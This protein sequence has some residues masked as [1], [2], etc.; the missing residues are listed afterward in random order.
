MRDPAGT[1]AVS[2]HGQC[3]AGRARALGMVGELLVRNGGRAETARKGAGY[4]DCAGAGEGRGM[5]SRAPRHAA[6]RR[7]GDIAPYRNGTA[8]RA[9]AREGAGGV[10]DHGVWAGER[11]G[12]GEVCG[13][14]FLVRG[15]RIW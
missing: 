1:V 11:A 13:R 6:R 9:R 12:W 4:R 10:A 8:Q 15:K 3:G 5:Q 7:D 2:H 14:R